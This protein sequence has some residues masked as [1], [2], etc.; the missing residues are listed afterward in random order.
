MRWPQ[1]IFEQFTV[2]FAT[3]LDASKDTANLTRQSPRFVE[4]R[5][6]DTA[7]LSLG[8]CAGIDRAARMIFRPY[9]VASMFIGIIHAARARLNTQG[10]LQVR[11]DDVRVEPW[12]MDQLL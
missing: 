12:G 7:R 3:A 4:T 1:I 10:M 5:D 11:S 2:A 9:Y 8:R 6:V